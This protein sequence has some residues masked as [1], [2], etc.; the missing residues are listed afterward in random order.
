MSEYWSNVKYGA[1][2]YIITPTFHYSN[3]PDLFE[4]MS[5]SDSLT[6]FGDRSQLSAALAG[7]TFKLYKLLY[8]EHY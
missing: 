3:T 2:P 1:N 7:L 8:A 4:N 6:R 5:T